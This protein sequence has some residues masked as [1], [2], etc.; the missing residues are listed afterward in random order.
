MFT[1]QEA[2]N[3]LGNEEM[4]YFINYEPHA[5][6]KFNNAFAE[7]ASNQGKCV[8]GYYF[9]QEPVLIKRILIGFEAI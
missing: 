8:L 2:R 1:L 9:G 4:D 7:I 3:T 6:Y 5:L